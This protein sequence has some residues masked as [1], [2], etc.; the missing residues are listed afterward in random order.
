[1]FLNCFINPRVF[2]QGNWR[3]AVRHDKQYDCTVGPHGSAGIDGINHSSSI[4][5]I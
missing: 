2:Y 3:T 1:M 5:I 4:R